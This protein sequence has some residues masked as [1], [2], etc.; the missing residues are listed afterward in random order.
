MSGGLAYLAQFMTI[1]DEERQHGTVT[2][3][4]NGDG[5]DQLGLSTGYSAGTLVDFHWYGFE[6]LEDFETAR[7]DFR[8]EAMNAMHLDEVEV[9][10][11]ELLYFDRQSITALV[12]NTSQ[13]ALPLNQCEVVMGLVVDGEDYVGLDGLLVDW[14]M[15]LEPTEAAIVVRSDHELIDYDSDGVADI[16]DGTGIYDLCPGTPDIQTSNYEGCSHYQLI[17]EPCTGVVCEPIEPTSECADE[18]TLRVY[19]T[20]GECVEGACEYPYTDTTCD[21]DCID[22]ECAPSTEADGDVD[23]DA[24]VDVD[25]D[26]DSDVDAD[27]D[28]DV[29]ADGDADSDSGADDTTGSEQGGCGCK[30]QVGSVAI[31]TVGVVALFGF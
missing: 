16:D 20:E 12:V 23:I 17:G 31:T 10:G 4:R 21:N 28:A 22:G 15:T 11:T 8:V 6:A 7:L 29:D 14:F 2:L 25:G 26:G 9:R 27:G 5:Y 24:D 13:G 19:E 30:Q 18:V 1:S 3:R